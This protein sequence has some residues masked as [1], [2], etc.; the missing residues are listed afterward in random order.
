MRNTFILTCAASTVTANLCLMTPDA[1]LAISLPF[2]LIAGISTVTWLFVRRRH[3]RER[4]QGTYRP[5]LP[6]RITGLVITCLGAIFLSVGMTQIVV[7]LSAR[8][9]STD[10]TVAQ[11]VIGA[12]LLVAG[13]F[14]WLK[15]STRLTLGP[16]S[17][18]YSKYLVFRGI[19]NYSDIESITTTQSGAVL[20]VTLRD[21]LGR[22]LDMPARSAN[23]DRLIQW[24]LVNSRP[25]IYAVFSDSHPMEI[26]KN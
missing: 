7:A 6:L 11:A 23:W 9:H 14:V 15:N 13:L 4:E 3:Q 1:L 24:A 17:F 2:L 25:D 20:T 12:V 21:I 8:T 10:D 22:K 16:E 19:I 18:S 5:P 26:K